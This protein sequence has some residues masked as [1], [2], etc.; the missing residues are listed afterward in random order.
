MPAMTGF[1][2]TI[3][4]LGTSQTLNSTSNPLSNG[5]AFSSTSP[6]A[7]AVTAVSGG[8]DTP[9]K[10]KKAVRAADPQSLKRSSGDTGSDDKT[11]RKKRAANPLAM[12]DPDGFSMSPISGSMVETGSPH[13]SIKAAKGRGRGPSRLTPKPPMVIGATSTDGGNDQRRFQW[14][15]TTDQHPT[16]A[17][18]RL[19]PMNPTPMPL[20]PTEGLPGNLND[21]MIFMDRFQLKWQDERLELITYGLTDLDR[22]QLLLQVATSPYGHVSTIRDYLQSRCEPRLVDAGEALRP[23]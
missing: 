20:L 17:G 6:T 12:L 13:G 21:L 15:K 10:I 5:V 18:A 16:S 14:P 4:A 22:I 19:F 3:S 2:P 8:A 1:R 23:T 9:K 7:A 11:V